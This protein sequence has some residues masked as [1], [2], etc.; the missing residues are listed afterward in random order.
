MHLNLPKDSLVVFVDETG[1]ELLNDPLQ[2]VFGIGGFAVLAQQLDTIVREPWREIRQLVAGSADAQLH[3]ADIVKPSQEQINAISGFFKIQPISRFGV[4][5][6]VETDI[7]DALTP[8]ILISEA[9]KLRLLHM[10]KWQ[11]F[12]SVEIIFEH[13]ERLAPMIENAF[14]TFEL[15]EDG[16]AIPVGFSWMPKSA[17]EPALEIADF[18][19]NAVGSEVRHRL[20]KRP[21]FAKN[22]EAFFHPA[23]NRLVSFMVRSAQVNLD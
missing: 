21:G 14:G 23:D 18:L 8:F 15:Y 19:A 20:A 11:P 1:H 13:S 17:R 12:Q 16:K 5:C 22:F 6:S 9:L 2:K 7:D 4:I 3:A 10:M